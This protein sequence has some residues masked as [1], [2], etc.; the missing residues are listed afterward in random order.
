MVVLDFWFD[1]T[2]LFWVILNDFVVWGLWFDSLLVFNFGLRDKFVLIWL[3]ITLVL[4]MGLL[5]LFDESTTLIVVCVYVW[6]LFWFKWFVVCFGLTL[7]FVLYFCFYFGFVIL[8]SF[9][10]LLIF[11]VLL[12][13]L[14]CF[15]VQLF[16][17]AFSY[18]WVFI[19]RFV[20][21]LRVIWWFEYWMC[22][23]VKWL[24]VVFLLCLFRLCFIINDRCG[25]LM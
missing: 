18:T 7:V 16:V 14:L 15:G 17:F 11:M 1:I 23:C 24:I 22:Y 25:L 13:Y 19:Y 21:W 5:W 3:M 20:V 6:F 10:I 12:I 2:Y 9:V 4:L 8:R